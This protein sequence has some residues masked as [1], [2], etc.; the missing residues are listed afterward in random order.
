MILIFQGNFLHAMNQ[1]ECPVCQFLVNQDKINDHLDS[2]CKHFVE[3][4]RKV[5]VV[6]KIQ[7][8]N[9]DETTSRT[10]SQVGSGS[11]SFNKS[12]QTN[13]EKAKPVNYSFTP[14]AELARPSEWKDYRGQK[15]VDQGSLLKSLSQ[16]GKLMSCLLWGPPGCG[17][18][19]LARIMGNLD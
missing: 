8:N 12:P 4:K 6:E 14:L 17:K 10:K 15:V 2:N 9:L 18:T 7:I 3:K 1:V 16:N 11:A 19:T 5:A 13:A